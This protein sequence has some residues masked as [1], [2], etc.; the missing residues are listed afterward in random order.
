MAKDIFMPGF[1]AFVAVAV[2]PLSAAKMALRH[3][4][5][6]KGKILLNM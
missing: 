3:A 4:H 1:I 5:A 6:P 2:K